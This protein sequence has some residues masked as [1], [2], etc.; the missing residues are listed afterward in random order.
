MTFLLPSLA[1][2]ALLP[3]GALAAAAA[4]AAPPPGCR[5]AETQAA[6]WICYG[7]E[8]ALAP[9]NATDSRQHFYTADGGGK[10]QHF[11]G[12]GPN[13]GAQEAVTLWL[14]QDYGWRATLSLQPIVPGLQSQAWWEGSRHDTDD[15]IISNVANTSAGNISAILGCRQWQVDGAPTLAAGA[16]IRPV[17]CTDLG[18]AGRSF[19]FDPPGFPGLIAAMLDPTLNTSYSG[20]CVAVDTAETAS[21]GSPNVIDDGNGA[22]F[23]AVF[24]GVGAQLSK[25]AAR[26]LLDYPAVQQAEIFDFLFRPGAGAGLQILELE[27]GGDGQ[28]VQGSTPSHM[29]SAAEQPNALRGTQG[30]I[31]Q[32]ARLR[33]PAVKLYFLPHSFPAWLGASPFE[34]PSAV[35]AY[36]VSYLVALQT[37]YGNGG[38]V[39]MT[40]DAIGIVSDLW[41][42]VLFPPYVV[43]LRA[44]LNAAG[45]QGTAIECADSTSGWECAEVAMSPLGEPLLANVGVFG[46]HHVP[47]AGSAPFKTGGRLWRTYMDSGGFISDL[48]GAAITAFGL[49]EASLGGM[50]AVVNWAGIDAQPDGQP[51]TGQGLIRADAPFS[52]HYYVTPKLWAVAHT[53]AFASAGWYALKTGAGSDALLPNGG[54]YVTRVSPDGN[55]WSIVCVKLA[56]ANVATN[57]AFVSETVTFTLRG[58]QLAAV[59]GGLV[60]VFQSNLGGSA[61]GNVTLMEDVGVASVYQPNGVGDF[62]FQVFLGTN[63]ITTI[64]SDTDFAKLETAPPSPG[65][66]P[67]IFELDFTDVGNGRA[68]PQPGQWVL[69]VNGAFETVDDPLA[70][71]GLQQVATGGKPFSRFKTETMPHAVLGDIAWTDVDAT[72]S[73]WLPSASDGALLGVRCSGL[74]DGANEHITGMD[75]LPGTW[76]AANLTHWTL[77]NRLDAAK[78]A[79]IKAGAFSTPLAAQAWHSMRLTARGARLVVSVNGVLLAVVDTAL[80]APLPK[81][82]FVGIGATSFGARP[83]FGSLNVKAFSSA[84]SEPPKEGH[85]LKEQGCEEGAEAQAWTVVAATGQLQ[86]LANSSLCVAS[87]RSFDVE[88]RY[89]NTRAAFVAVCNASDARQVFSVETT[90]QDGPYRSGPITGPD[91]LTINIFGNVRT[92]NADIAMYGIH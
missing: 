79:V 9:C 42:S 29:H 21:V 51:E 7:M 17:A 26:L 20:L 52:G 85:E 80:A 64:T 18:L 10:L 12:S 30:W 68:P 84:C 56:T 57:A 4:A 38:A 48:M 67:K 8:L 82:G 44:A 69:D 70:G 86:S 11:Y 22:N 14:G 72:A 43:A 60:R 61:S 1:L 90:V 62:V 74:G 32:Q 76:L 73:V 13:A 25:G 33:N 27:V 58:R 31:A 53:S 39:N 37:A 88:Y 81:N 55:H 46:G 15:T 34:N 78:L 59:R 36:V 3:R 49:N 75:E 2:A 16:R 40:A 35:A 54:S 66:F 50:N 5:E 71:R 45:M 65:A 28:V 63:T 91:G 87:N 77:Q 83:I 47:A 23:G 92:D 24:D 6:Q 89:Q 41:D 19:S